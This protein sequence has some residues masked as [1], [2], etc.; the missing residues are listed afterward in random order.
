MYT[1]KNV[2]HKK[3]CNQVAV[4]VH[5]DPPL[6]MLIKNKNDE[7]LDKDCLKIKLC[8]DLTSAKLDIY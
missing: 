4:Q 1:M 6:I 5:V 2:Y 8:G 7:K 3:N